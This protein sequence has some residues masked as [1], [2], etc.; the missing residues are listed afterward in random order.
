MGSDVKGAIETS[1][2]NLATAKAENPSARI[3]LVIASDLVDEVSLTLPRRL[4]GIDSKGV[5][6]MAVQDAGNAANDYTS[7]NVVIVGA[8]NSKVNTRTLDQVQAYWT[9][10]LNQIG[11]TNITEQSDLSG[12]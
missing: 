8:R 12:F 10:Y 6:E 7:V 9:C 11:I 5:C 3:T 2:K 1:L 4:N